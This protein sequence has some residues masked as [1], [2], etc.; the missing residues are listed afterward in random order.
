M[1]PSEFSHSPTHTQVDAAPGYDLDGEVY[2]GRPWRDLARVIFQ[3]T[4]L[5]DVINDA[6]WNLSLDEEATPIFEEYDNTGDGAGTSARLYETKAAAAV[7]M[8]QLWPD[9]YSWIDSTY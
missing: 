4:E 6:G 1:D 3:N 2:L 5:S 8:A 9:G 7:T